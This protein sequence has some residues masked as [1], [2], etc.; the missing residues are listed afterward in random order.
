[1]LPQTAESGLPV[2]A[3]CLK[4]PLD[5]HGDV[6]TSGVYAGTQEAH[7]HHIMGL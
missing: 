7:H 6:V 1:V 4:W 2:D 3:E 5:C